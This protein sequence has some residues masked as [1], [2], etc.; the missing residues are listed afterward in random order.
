[1]HRYLAEAGRPVDI[2]DVAAALDILRLP[3]VGYRRGVPTAWVISQIWDVLQKL[4]D[5]DE[6]AEFV[7]DRY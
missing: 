7:D 2:A 5:V 1:M 4:G 3:R 6:P